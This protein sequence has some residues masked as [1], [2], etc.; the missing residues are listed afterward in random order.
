MDVVK[1]KC[2]VENVK[3]IKKKHD[4]MQSTRRREKKPTR[5]RLLYQV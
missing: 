2:G 3:L 4:V 5:K 1:K